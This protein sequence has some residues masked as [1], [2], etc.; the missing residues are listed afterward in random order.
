MKG[1]LLEGASKLTEITREE[2]FESITDAKVKITKAMITDN[3]I[4]LYSKE[5]ES[6][7]PIIF[8]SFGVGLICEVGSNCFGISK[9]KRVYI[10]PYAPCKN[11]NSCIGEKES[12]CSNLLVAGE[13]IDGFIKNFGIY[14]CSRLF[15]LPDSIS[16][17]EAIY[18]EY[19]SLA[20]EIIDKLK[21]KKCE[22][23]AILGGGTLGNILAQLISYYQAVPILIDNDEKNVE[24]SKNCGIYY[25]F[26]NDSDIQKKINNITGGQMA[27]KVIYISNSQINTR[28]AL[29]L[30]RFGASVAYVGFEYTSITVNLA[31]AMKKQLQILAINNGWK[32]TTT[33]INLLINK[34]VNVEF[35]AKKEIKFNEVENET[36]K[37]AI[38][39]EKN[40]TISDLIVNFD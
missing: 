30:A 19:I 29:S 38:Q 18:I 4:S 31:L 7:N 40:G 12:E 17:S 3:D 32:N 8:G 26:K 36:K 28:L 25:S 1:L 35:L 37:L 34:A 9:N 5:R 15:E 24:A 16:Y 11:C 21:I 10:S 13:T 33:A 23:I 39:Y 27:E 6:F 2:Q 22:H 20:V 14:P